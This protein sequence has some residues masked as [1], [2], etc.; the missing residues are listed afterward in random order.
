MDA[1]VD[2]L[3][4]FLSVDLKVSETGSVIL[5]KSISNSSNHQHYI[6]LLSNL[7]NTYLVPSLG[8][9][10]SI[11]TTHDV[12]IWTSEVQA[13]LQEFDIPLELKSLSPEIKL[14]LLFW[15]VEEMKCL[16]LSSFQFSPDL[17]PISLP[18]LFFNK[19]HET[20]NK[21]LPISP[22]NIPIIS[23]KL[24]PDQW[25]Y[26]NELKKEL[27]EEYSIR[28][29]ML[30]ARLDST[31]QSFTWS[32]R[33]D[34][35]KKITV[36]ETYGM[37]KRDLITRPNV[38]LGDLLA[39]SQSSLRF[40]K[41]SSSKNKASSDSS[42]AKV[43]MGRVPDRGGRPRESEAPP[44]EVPSWQQNN[45][46]RGGYQNRGRGQKSQDNRGQNNLNNKGY[47]NR[48]GQGQN[49]QSYDRSGQ[50]QYNQSY[51]NRGTQGQYNQGYENRGEQGQYNQSY[52]NRGGQGQYSQGYDNRVTIISLIKGV[53][54]MVIEGEG[55]DMGIMEIILGKNVE[56]KI[57]VSNINKF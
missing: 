52:D 8:A 3:S 54:I 2:Q 26:L 40:E 22:G 56:F 23:Q 32:N 9:Q 13:F 35:K 14:D 53:V 20:L 42:F 34:D 5:K 41:L 31:I 10:N 47:H 27:N 24:S 18:S 6:K 29:V 55:E 50:V 46:G 44:P 39:A 7:I 51:S 16:R 45:R 38:S 25:G 43:K 37:L 15:I 49:S 57:I 12:N 36:E 21:A 4:S 48:G 33:L 1:K 28:W 11:Q 17:H 30:L 19:L